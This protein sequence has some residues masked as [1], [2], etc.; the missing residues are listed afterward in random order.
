MKKT[1]IILGFLLA[2]AV[3]TAAF[4]HHE[5]G[6]ACPMGAGNEHGMREQSPCPVTNM[7]LMQA[8][9]AVEH[10]KDLGLTAD[11]IQAI[12]D[13]KIEAKKNNIRMKAEMEI[14]EID[15]KVMMKADKF[16]A[17]AFKAMMDKGM[18]QMMENGKKV[19]D[20]YAKFRSILKP[21]QYARLL[22]MD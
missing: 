11:Q 20:W 5:G 2:F 10:S 1:A 18:P 16:D 7:L 22:E 8:H 17:E 19:V 13:I 3:S 9:E 21:E 12:R 4:A 15:M 14:M 6:Q